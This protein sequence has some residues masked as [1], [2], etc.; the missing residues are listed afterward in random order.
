MEL[1]GQYIGVGYEIKL[2]SAESLLHL[3]IVVAKAI[4]PGDL[5]AHREVINSLELVEALVEVAL[6][7]G[8]APQDVPL[9]RV[10]VVECVSF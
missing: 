10:G 3:H 1:I 2:I 7:A 8:G 9:V 6:A 4:L 5:I